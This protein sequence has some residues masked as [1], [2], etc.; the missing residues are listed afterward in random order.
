MGCA[1]SLDSEYWRLRVADGEPDISQAC[2]A[3]RA[4]AQYLYCFDGKV[5]LLWFWLNADLF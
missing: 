4:G 5:N 1:P 2:A 3:H